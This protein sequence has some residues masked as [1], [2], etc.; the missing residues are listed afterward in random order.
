MDL[1]WDYFTVTPKMSS[2]V[3]FLLSSNALGSAGMCGPAS[4]TSKVLGVRKQQRCCY[5]K[6]YLKPTTVQTP[7][8]QKTWICKILLPYLY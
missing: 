2:V 4:G 7:Q 6:I 3:P 1:I 8:Q 5:V